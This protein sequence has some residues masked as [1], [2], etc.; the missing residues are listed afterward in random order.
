[1]WLSKGSNKAPS[2]DRR[3]VRALSFFRPEEAVNGLAAQP[4]Q[5]APEGMNADTCVSPGV[6]GAVCRN[7][8]A[9]AVESVKGMFLPLPQSQRDSG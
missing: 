7:L 8:P 9:S 2:R 4:L 3:G 1:M 6:E 5:I